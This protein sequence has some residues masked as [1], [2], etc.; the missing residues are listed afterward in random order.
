[1]IKEFQDYCWSFY[2]PGEIYGHFFEDKL[3][4]IELD[5]A[6]VLRS[7][8][9]SFDGDSIDRECVREILFKARSK[10]LASEALLA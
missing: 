8:S 5:A 10:T 9:E 1:M 3:T 2:A 4:R 7:V 6:C